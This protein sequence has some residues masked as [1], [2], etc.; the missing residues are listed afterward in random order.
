VVL[1]FVELSN[2]VT[3][4]DNEGHLYLSI[5]DVVVKSRKS[6]EK[7]RKMI[8]LL[9]VFFA[10]NVFSSIIFHR[11]RIGSESEI[12]VSGVEPMTL[13]TFDA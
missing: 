4:T 13:E 9:S 2:N 7:V 3:P 6:N 1:G 5:N 8:N 12:I 11:Q 10:G